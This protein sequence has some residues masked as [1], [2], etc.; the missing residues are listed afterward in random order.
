MPETPAERPQAVVAA[1][2]VDAKRREIAASVRSHLRQWGAHGW[3]IVGPASALRV[4]VTVPKTVLTPRAPVGAIEIA[5]RSIMPRLHA[6]HA[7]VRRER[8][9]MSGD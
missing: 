7:H 3:R 6:S 5:G 9:T 2:F 8:R 4:E 1:A